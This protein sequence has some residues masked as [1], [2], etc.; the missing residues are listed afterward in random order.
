MAAFYAFPTGVK[1]KVPGLLDLHGGGQ[2]A[3][4]TVVTF[5]AQNGYAGLSINWG[6][7]PMEGMKEGRTRTPTG[8]RLTPRRSTTTTYGTMKPDAKTLDGCESPRNNNW[9][10]L[11][12]A[13]RRGLTFLEQQPEVDGRRLG[14]TGHSMGGKL[15]TDLG[16]HRRARPGGR[17][18]LRRR[19]CGARENLG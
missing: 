1:E 7:N 8:G 3:S 17:T 12:L 16:R 19:R 4:L 14:V 10:L 5:Q 11:V 18:V 13:A 15:T 2:R 6:G 9:F